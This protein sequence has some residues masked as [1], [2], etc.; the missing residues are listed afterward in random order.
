VDIHDE[1]HEPAV[2]ADS[3][4]RSTA[5]NGRHRERSRRHVSGRRAQKARGARQGQDVSASRRYD[6]DPM[7][8]PRLMVAPV[9]TSLGAKGTAIVWFRNDLRV[10]DNAALEL[11][12]TAAYIIPLYVFDDRHF[13][14]RSAHQ[15]QRTGMMRAQFVL[16]SVLGLQD[17]LRLKQSDLVV[18]TGRPHE[19]IGEIARVVLDSGY[20]PVQ[21]IAQK[22]VTTEEIDMEEK[23]R[24]H[25]DMLAQGTEDQKSVGLHFVWGGTLL[26]IEDLPFNPAGPALPAS[27]TEFRNLVESGDNWKVRDEFSCPGVLQT[28]PPGIAVASDNTESLQAFL[29]RTISDDLVSSRSER[30]QRGVLDFKGGEIEGE[31]RLKDWMWRKDRLRTYFDTRNQSGNSDF[32]SKLSPWL[33]LGCV[34][35]KTIYWNCR[36][37]EEEVVSNKSTYWMV[38]ELLT[39]DYFRLVAAN[40]RKQLFALNGFTGRGPS[41]PDIWALAEGAIT[42]QHKGRLDAW[43]SGRTGAPFVDASMREMA[44]TGFMSNRGRQNVAS[45]LIH[46]LEY[47]DWRA[48]AEYFEAVL[49]DYDAA[50]NWGNW[51]YLAGVGT[52][53]RG[54]RRFNVVKQSMVYDPQGLYIRQWCNELSSLPAEYLHEPH[55]APAPVFESVSYPRPI[56]PLMT[57]SRKNRGSET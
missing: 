54:G 49:I 27:F 1:R 52:D 4:E 32:S 41:D 36:R 7:A 8:G 2:S 51:A 13:G 18:R 50:S 48:G 44:A 38:F 22:E 43:I 46:D 12:N 11:A 57:Y 17:G 21:V 24:R 20:G 42:S 30:G 28:F 25:L 29:E 6:G 5:E 56:V 40:A 14:T 34:S 19:I 39:R 15:F 10:S 53:P 9:P 37:Y 35:P 33:A 16:E 55:R 26:H 3:A 45:F 23:V 47:P 31:E